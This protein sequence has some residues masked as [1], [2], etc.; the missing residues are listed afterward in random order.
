M[1]SHCAITYN[2]K[3]KRPAAVEGERAWAV[4]VVPPRFLARGKALGSLYRAVPRRSTGLPGGQPFCGGLASDVQRRGLRGLSAMARRL[5]AAPG[6]LLFSFYVDVRLAR[7][8]HAGLLVEWRS[9]AIY[10]KRVLQRHH[11]IFPGNTVS[12]SRRSWLPDTVF[13]GIGF[14]R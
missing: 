4:S 2:A 10:G 12:G 9:Y 3:Q 6:R 1:L 8:Y 14:Q 13:P 7:L 11:G 5:F